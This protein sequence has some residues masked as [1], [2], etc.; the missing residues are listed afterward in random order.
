MS[1]YLS[2]LFAAFSICFLFACNASKESASETEYIEPNR[3]DKTLF[4]RGKIPKEN[5]V[6]FGQVRLF[7]IDPKNPQGDFLTSKA[8]DAEGNFEFKV[9]VLQPTYFALQIF[10]RQVV[11][12][13][14]NKS[15]ISI[16]AD[17]KYNGNYT[18]TGCRD[19]DLFESFLTLKNDVDFKAQH[20]QPEEHREYRVEKAK[21]FLEKA[22]NSIVSLLALDLF[23]FKDEKQN[24]IVA[25]Q[26]EHLKKTYPS[27]PYVEKFA[28]NFSGV[29]VPEVGDEAPDIELVSEGKTVKLSSLRGKYVLLDFSKFKDTLLTDNKLLA[30]AYSKYKDKGFEMITVSMDPLDFDWQWGAF[31]Q[32][33][34]TWIG[35]R[36]MSET[37]LESDCAKKY[38]VNPGRTPQTFFIN[39]EGKIISKQIRGRDLEAVLSKIFDSK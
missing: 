22:K 6:E 37:K 17:G 36:D 11:T 5:L 35:V 14:L 10:D 32:N 1:K 9:T 23:E 33:S 12:F 29:R 21:K 38:G 24:K 13:L 34:I 15:D 8:P 31:L 16:T 2:F 18:L 27:N 25:E 4:I 20:M 39:P 19:S 7:K 30:R 26:I 3:P 28:S